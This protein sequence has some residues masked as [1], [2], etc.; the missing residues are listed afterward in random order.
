MPRAIYIPEVMSTLTA[1]PPVRVCT[2]DPESERSEP[3]RVFTYVY[4]TFSHAADVY[5]QS[6]AASNTLSQSQSH[7]NGVPK[8]EP[9]REE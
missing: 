9:Q 5:I 3:G 7:S 2:R 4:I 8:G 1:P 6:D